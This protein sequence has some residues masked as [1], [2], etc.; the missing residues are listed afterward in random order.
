MALGL[1]L[2]S[3]QFLYFLFSLYYLQVVGFLASIF[4]HITSLRGYRFLYISHSLYIFQFLL[5]SFI[6]ELLSIQQLSYY[7]SLV[8]ELLL[9]VLVWRVVFFYR[10]L[11][12]YIGISFIAQLVALGS[13]LLV[14]YR[15]VLSPRFRSRIVLLALLLL[16][17]VG[18]YI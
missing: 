9:R 6:L 12:F 8:L 2:I 4:R 15:L 7:I 5:D 14:P 16:Y 17:I 11:Q 10:P 1:H 13:F 18:V 3:Q